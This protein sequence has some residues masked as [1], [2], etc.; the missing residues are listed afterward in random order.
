MTHLGS[1]LVKKHPNHW[2]SKLLILKIGSEYFRYV[3]EVH[4]FL[5]RWKSVPNHISNKFTLGS[6]T[7]SHS[8]TMNNSATSK[9]KTAFSNDDNDLLQLPIAECVL[10]ADY[11]NGSELHQRP[12]KG[13]HDTLTKVL[14]HWVKNDYDNTLKQGTVGCDCRKLWITEK[15]L[16]DNFSK[17]RQIIKIIDK[18]VIDQGGAITRLEA[19]KRLDEDR[20]CK[21]QRVTK[22]WLEWKKKNK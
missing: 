20:A 18:E 14:Q 21:N 7:A 17:R 1:I 22:Y 16:D 15:G 3:E 5:K 13:I 19:A 11:R 12:P 8:E 2:L 6:A 10:Q 4:E 9:V